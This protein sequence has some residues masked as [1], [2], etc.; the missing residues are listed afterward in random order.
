MQLGALIEAIRPRAVLVPSDVEIT[1]VTYRADAAVPGALHVCVPGHTADGHDFAAEA[2][3]RGAAALVV[4]RGLGLGVTEVEVE[5]ARRAMAA[6]ADAFYGRPSAQLSVVGITGT[7]GKTTTAFLM[8]AVLEAAG[9][10]SGLLG[11]VEQRVG[12]RVEPVVRTTPESVDLQALLRRMADAGDTACVME[13]SSHALQ[14]D[15]VA[16]VRFAAAAFTNLTQDH[17]DFHPDME[18]YFRAKAR[19]FD[20]PGLGT[21]V[22]NVDDAFGARLAR[23]LAGRVRVIGY[24][25]ATRSAVRVDDYLAPAALNGVATGQLGVFN[26]ANAL[27]VLG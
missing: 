23:K 18:H 9:R 7:N 10:R 1:A 14:L 17:L 2:V 19:L 27:G 21:A 12:G 13:V 6:A 11:T 15:R 20:M 24:G 4:E 26:V 25:L 3:R 22:L 8:H 5:S 16:G